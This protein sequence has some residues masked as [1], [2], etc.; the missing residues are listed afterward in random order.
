MPAKKEQIGVFSHVGKLVQAHS[1][2]L[3]MHTGAKRLPSANRSHP[4]SVVS[5]QRRACAQAVAPGFWKEGRVPLLLS[6]LLRPG[7][8]LGDL[9]CQAGFAE[10]DSFCLS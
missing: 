6:R 9:V 1:Y 2:Q 3:S 10:P 8:G 5:S 4:L 7:G